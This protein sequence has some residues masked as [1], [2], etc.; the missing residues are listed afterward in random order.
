MFKEYL[1]QT[2]AQ[3]DSDADIAAHGHNQEHNQQF[4]QVVKDKKNS[5]ASSAL[6]LNVVANERET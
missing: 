1:P 3:N 6:V 4:D 5:S 2:H